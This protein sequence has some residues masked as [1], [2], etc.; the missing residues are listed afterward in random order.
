MAKKENRLPYP[1]KWEEIEAYNG[2]LITIT[3][4]ATEMTTETDNLPHKDVWVIVYFR[5][6][7]SFI[8]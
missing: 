8:L 1:F 3:D 5:K 7:V 6:S 4:L 2:N